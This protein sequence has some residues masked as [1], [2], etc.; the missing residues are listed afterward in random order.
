MQRCTIHWYLR[1]KKGSA[2]SSWIYRIRKSWDRGD[3]DYNHQRSDLDWRNHGSHTVEPQSLARISNYSPGKIY[4]RSHD[5]HSNR[6]PWI[7]SPV[8][9]K[10][11]YTWSYHKKPHVPRAPGMPIWYPFFGAWFGSTECSLSQEL[12]MLEEE[13][14][15]NIGTFMTEGGSSDITDT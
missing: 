14:W 5:F 12:H 2:N 10:S 8:V 7:Y 13:I 1:D 11:N 9:F 6:G 15:R 4:C 3:L